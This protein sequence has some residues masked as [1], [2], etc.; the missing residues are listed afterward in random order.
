MSRANAKRAGVADIT[1]F[2]ERAI[3]EL[4]APAGS[5]PGIV[6]INPPYG[7]RIGEKA[8]LKSLYRA[9]G[10]TL[11]SRFSGW[12]VGLITNEVALAQATG[13]PF[14]LTAEPVLHGGL[15]VTLFRTGPL[16]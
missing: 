7:D 15:R 4:T 11:L 12:R 10:Q 16:P 6:I 5:P 2:E 8:R 13:L 14:S 3:E 1:E 9:M